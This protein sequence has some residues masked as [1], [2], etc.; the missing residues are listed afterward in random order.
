MKPKAEQRRD[1]EDDA[2]AGDGRLGTGSM[3]RAAQ[4]GV[5]EMKGGAGA[6]AGAGTNKAEAAV[7]AAA[8]E[9]V[10]ADTGS[11]VVFCFGQGASAP[12]SLGS[13]GCLPHALTGELVDESDDHCHWAAQNAWPS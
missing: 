5:A 12:S 1:A 6:Q 4:A 2:L 13:Y 11:V 3:P 7:G 8:G 10:G 9:A